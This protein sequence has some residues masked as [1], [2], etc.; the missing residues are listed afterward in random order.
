MTSHVITLKDHNIRSQ[1][2]LRPPLL[3]HPQAHQPKLLSSA[4]LLLVKLLLGPSDLVGLL[5]PHRLDDDPGVGGVAVTL[6]HHVARLAQEDKARPGGGVI[7]LIVRV[8]HPVTVV[9]VI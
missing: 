1:S 2:V 5:V 3:L 7:E 9:V 8:P 6:R 4:D